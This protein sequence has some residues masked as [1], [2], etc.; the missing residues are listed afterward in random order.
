MTS[1]N[2]LSS[3]YLSVPDVD[4]LNGCAITPSRS[5]VADD[6][7]RK[8]TERPTLRS[9]LRFFH[10]ANVDLCPENNQ[11]GSMRNALPYLG[12]L[13][14]AGLFWGL[15][16]SL[17]PSPSVNR[18]A[19][20][21]AATSPSPTRPAEN[22]SRETDRP[23]GDELGPLRF[24][25]ETRK[26]WARFRGEDRRL[27]LDPEIQEKVEAA[28]GKGRPFYGATV[29]MDAKNGQIL[30]LAEY[31]QREP[32]RSGVALRADTPAASIFKLVSAAA[33]LEAR[34]APEEAVCVS[35]GKRRLAPK[36]LLDRPQDRCVRFGDVVPLSLNA[37]MAKLADR[38]LPPGHLSRMAENLGFGRALPIE[39]PMEP[40]RADIPADAFGRANTAA[41]FGDVR[42]SALHA[43]ILTSLIANRGEWIAPRLFDTAVHNSMS[44][45]L[46]APRLEPSV[47]IPL[48]Q[49]MEETTTRGTARRLFSRIGRHS[50][51]RNMRVGAKTGSLLYY[52]DHVD[53]SWLVAFAPARNPRFVVASVVVN[54]WQ[55]WYTKAGPLAVGALEAAF[56]S[57][58]RHA[59]APVSSP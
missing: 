23:V 7:Q 2:A 6:M 56:E 22:A 32:E 25:A 38:N 27:T 35:G 41:G 40:S 26:Y 16:W 10:T 14:V 8:N 45:P 54:D 20:P 17:S 19:K 53:H 52:D 47:A 48:A 44:E 39:I 4:F 36:H 42:M 59:S 28:L 3:P 29:V 31:S 15:A 5:V 58:G 34:V 9:H 43:A 30:A 49:M 12:A 24:D 46:Q 33:L 51:L 1:S 13:A 11:K 21:Q 37:A 57:R 55:L 50:P 18:S